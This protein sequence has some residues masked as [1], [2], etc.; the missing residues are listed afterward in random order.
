[1]MQ[2]ARPRPRWYWLRFG[3][4]T[5]SGSGLPRGEHLAA[6][7]SGANGAPGAVPAMWPYLA[8]EAEADELQP[9]SDSWEPTPMTVAEHHA[10]VLFGLHQQGQGTLV[11]RPGVGIATSVRDL[12]VRFSSEAVDRRFLAAVTADDVGE[13][14]FHLRGLVRQLKG[15]GPGGA[16]DYTQ[17]VRDLQHWP[18][19]NRR[20]SIRR[21]WGRQYHR[22]QDDGDGQS[23]RA[24]TNPPDPGPTPGRPDE[25]Q[26]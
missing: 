11:H 25:E 16:V 10:L 7:R 5:A 12:R 20:Q 23:D 17:L 13:F 18:D 24:T 21:R 4:E 22:A 19:T 3:D 6:L 26:G 2:E 1:M 9:W 8:T 15:L 14:A